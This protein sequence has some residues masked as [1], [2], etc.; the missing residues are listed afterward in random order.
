[1]GERRAELPSSEAGPPRGVDAATWALERTQIQNPRIRTFLGCLRMLDDLIESDYTIM[2][3]S[4]ARLAALW[5]EAG[6]FSEVIRK[7][8]LPCLAAPSEI[9]E[10]EEARRN[11][12]AAL[13]ALD[14]TV[15]S[16]LESAFDH[17]P[18]HQMEIRELLCV[19]FGQIQACL[20]ETFGKIIA[21]DPRSEHDADYYLSKRFPLDSEEAEWL[22]AGVSELDEYLRSLKKERRVLLT[23]LATKIAE[24]GVIPPDGIWSELCGLL[25]DLLNELSTKLRQLLSLRGI[26]Y[27]ETRMLNTYAVDVPTKCFALFDVYNLG[28]Q[29]VASVSESEPAATAEARPAAVEKCHAIFS[30]RLASL[31]T[32]LD[33]RIDGL[34]R[35]VPMWLGNIEK[36]RALRFES[37][38]QLELDD[39]LGRRSDSRAGH[40]LDRRSPP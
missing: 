28:L 12:E 13:L 35:F 4:P 24:N 3:C 20:R 7:E 31:I 23:G 10:L 18:L 40:A 36:R 17:A 33:E 32:E 2:H 34:S 26:R 22:Y 6:R 27:E 21:A 8:L 1:M 29:T 11:A 16:E 39:D 30:A 37:G 15:L 19:S 9:K 5:Q 38:P 25:L 14:N